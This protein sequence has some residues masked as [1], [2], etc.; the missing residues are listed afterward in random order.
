MNIYNLCIV[1]DLIIRSNNQMSLQFIKNCAVTVTKYIG[2]VITG[3]FKYSVWGAS[4]VAS[5]GGKTIHMFT[6]RLKRSSR[7][8]M[9]SRLMIKYPF[10][11]GYTINKYKLPEDMSEFLRNKHCIYI[12]CI[13]PGLY[14]FGITSDINTR[15]TTHRRVLGYQLIVKIYTFA[16]RAQIVAAETEFKRY[17]KNKKI[18]TSYNGQHEIVKTNVDTIVS[19]FDH[20]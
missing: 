15:L 1:Y 7:L 10:R 19:W 18:I 9:S 8:T 2:A 14:K 5:M 3:S 11:R 17:A 6:Q 4:T 12:L 16:T 20:Y 13:R